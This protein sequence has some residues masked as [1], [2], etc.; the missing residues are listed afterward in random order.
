MMVIEEDKQSVTTGFTGMTGRWARASTLNEVQASEQ[1]PELL[2]ED[3]SVS[4]KVDA[5]ASVKEDASASVED[6]APVSVKEQDKE[7]VKEADVVSVTVTEQ[8]SVKEAEQLS[9][10][11]PLNALTGPLDFDRTSRDCQTQKSTGLS[12]VKSYVFDVDD[13]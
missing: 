9:V 13:N 12:T 5:S 7:S 2:K 11:Q 8:E 4:I 10:K 3:V 6:D 1:T